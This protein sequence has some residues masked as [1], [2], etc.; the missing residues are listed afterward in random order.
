MFLAS[1]DPVWRQKTIICFT[2]LKGQ[3]YDPLIHWRWQNAPLCLSLLFRHQHNKCFLTIFI[4]FWLLH[5]SI[6]DDYGGGED[7]GLYKSVSD[8]RL[9]IFASSKYSL[10]YWGGVSMSSIVKPTT[11]DL[12]ICTRYC[13]WF[14]IRPNTKQSDIDYYGFLTTRLTKT[15]NV[16]FRGILQ[17]FVPVSSLPDEYQED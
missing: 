12:R 5:W 8:C 2:W 17:I 7:A 15:E 13:S 6:E 10:K 4:C 1:I 3:Y 16:C 11:L 9:W 14:V